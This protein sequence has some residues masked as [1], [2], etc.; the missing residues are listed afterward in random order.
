MP[1]GD[2]TARAPLNTSIPLVT[3]V[4]TSATGS[5]AVSNLVDAY[6]KGFINQDD[7]MNRVGAVAQA[8]NKALMQELSEYVSPQAIQAR[9]AQ[10]NLQGQSAAAQAQLVQPLLEKQ[11]ADIQQ[12]QLL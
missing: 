2:A 8:K 6:H 3:P 4:D 1:V 9:Q 5:E 11:Q 12:E 7:I 10:M